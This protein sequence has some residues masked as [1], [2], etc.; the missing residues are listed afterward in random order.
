MGE[1][2]VH[3]EVVDVDI[4]NSKVDIKGYYADIASIYHSEK[5]AAHNGGVL[6]E[7]TTWLHIPTGI[8]CM[9]YDFE[10]GKAWKGTIADFEKGD[11]VYS[12]NTSS[13]PLGLVLIKNYDKR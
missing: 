13:Y 11:E 6:R 2:G 4:Q 3:G 7:L 10:T 8:S 1:G 12:Y 9:V 5:Y